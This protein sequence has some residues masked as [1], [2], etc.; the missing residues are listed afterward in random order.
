MNLVSGTTLGLFEIVASIAAGGMGEVYRA[1][2]IRRGRKVAIKISV[3]RFTDRFERE[4]RVVVSPNNPNYLVME[5]IEGPTFAERFQRGPTPLLG[6][7]EIARRMAAGLEGAHQ[8]LMVHRDCETGNVKI[9]P[10]STGRVLDFDSAKLPAAQAGA[11][12]NAAD[13]VTVLLNFLYEPRPRT[14]GAPPT[15][16]K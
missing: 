5:H 1:Q 7:V 11:S 4:A 10:D 6:A 8:G 14:E 9:E 13:S 16:G 15:G 2:D 12:A 3:E